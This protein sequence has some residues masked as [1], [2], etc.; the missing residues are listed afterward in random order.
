MAVSCGRPSVHSWLP[1]L[2]ALV[3]IRTVNQW[4]RA[5][6]LSVAC[7]FLSLCL[8]N[9]YN[10]FPVRTVKCVTIQWNNTCPTEKSTKCLNIK[11][12]WGEGNADCSDIYAI[13]PYVCMS[14]YHA[15]VHKI[16]HL[17]LVH[18]NKSSKVERREFSGE[19]PRKCTLMH[20]KFC[21]F[22]TSLLV[23]SPLI[24]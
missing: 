13:Y 11:K 7:L 2:P 16:L 19:T 20:Y 15:A 17:L 22:P 21:I 9:K 3:G 18:Q 1:T 4:T 5:L 23:L 6:S 12:W 8:S 10:F 24:Y 14:K